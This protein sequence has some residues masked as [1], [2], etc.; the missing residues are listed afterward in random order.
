MSKLDPLLER[1]RAFQATGAYAGLSLMPAHPVFVVT[2]LDPRVDP[3]A[4]LGLGLGDA[5]VVRN[6]GGRVT[7]S[8]I[9]DVA[10]ISYMIGAVLTEGPLFEVAVIHHTGCGTG[11]LADAGF[12]SA[13]ATRTGIDESVLA[14]EAV[15]DP[16]E[17]VAAD[18]NRLLASPKVS[19]RI[20][21]AG[22]VYDV[23]DGLVRMI[24]PPQ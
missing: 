1:N 14:G 21:A 4:F 17:T 7:E 8:V 10:F 20:T 2:C 13:F 11:V 23:D 3:A 9:D 15:V 19:D 5:P 24:V 22:Y 12:R 18:V 6:A 16:E